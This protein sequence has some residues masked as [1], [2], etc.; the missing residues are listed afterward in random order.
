LN[1]L[2]SAYC[3]PCE[4]LSL[5]DNPVGAE[6]LVAGRSI[7]CEVLKP[8]Q[9]DEVLLHFCLPELSTLL[10]WQHISERTFHA[11][12]NA[13]AKNQNEPA[14]LSIFAT[15]YFFDRN[16]RPLLVYVIFFI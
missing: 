1:A 9:Y 4:S 12:L 13:T 7:G 6:L 15:V 16:I 10:Q 3:R 14:K 5:R 11:L 2:F 8:G